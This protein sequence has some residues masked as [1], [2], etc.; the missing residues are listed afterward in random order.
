MSNL[1]DHEDERCTVNTLGSRHD[2]ADQR[3]RGM[4]QPQEGDVVW[5]EIVVQWHD[6]W[7]LSVVQLKQPWP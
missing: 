2:P 7:A 5:G 4:E 6:I 3:Y 1:I